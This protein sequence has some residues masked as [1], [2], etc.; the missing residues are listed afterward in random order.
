MLLKIA[1][2]YLIYLLKI[3]I[4]HSYVGL[5]EGNFSQKSQEFR[6]GLEMCDRM[7]T[8][9]RVLGFDG[10]SWLGNERFHHI[11]EVFMA[12]FTRFHPVLPHDFPN[13]QLQLGCWEH[14]ST[15]APKQH[16]FSWTLAPWNTDIS[17]SI[18][19]TISIHIINIIKIINKLDNI[20]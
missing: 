2:L 9:W 7:G 18:N 4:F 6:S 20:S 3:V 13:P 12:D 16:D 1:H 8:Q 19:I 15:G 17:I 14:R 11:L 10:H 5:P